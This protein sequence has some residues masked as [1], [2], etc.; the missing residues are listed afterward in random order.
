M[1]EVKQLANKLFEPLWKQ[2][3]RY[4]ILMGGRGR[5]ASTAASQYLLSNLLAPDFFRS[6]IMRAVHSDIR[7]SVWRELNDRIAEQEIKDALHIADNDMRVTYGK[8]TIQAHGFK[9]SSGSHTAKLKSLANYNVVDIDEADEVNEPEFMVLDDSLR[10]VKGDIAIILV[11]NPPPKNHWIIQRFFDLEESG[12]PGFFIPK[13]KKDIDNVVFIGG[14]FRDNIKNLDAETVRRYQNYKTNKPDYYYQVIEGLVPETV[15]GKIYSGWQL[16]EGVPDGARLVK[17][18]EGFGWFPDPACA[19]A[20]YYW[21]GGYVLD[22]LA[23]GTELTNEFLAT[24]IKENQEK[25][26][27]KVQT[28]AD[29][30]EPKSISEQNRYGISVVGCAKGKDSVAFRIKVVSQKKIWVTKRSI[31]IWKSY[32]NY[33]WDEDKDGNPKGAPRHMWSHA[34]DAIGY[35]IA[36]M[37]NKTMDLQTRRDGPRQRT[38]IAV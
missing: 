28:V 33:A 24:A 32:E 38:N 21:N 34:M 12:V 26:G 20:I 8:N 13:L 5:G 19:A 37:H 36:E 17:N 27:V 31:N 29:S 15:R 1:V 9:A 14:T 23:Y 11:L 2:K 25:V 3:A 4:Y 7:H 18:G 30:A 22:E 10:T 6:A 16:I 35:P